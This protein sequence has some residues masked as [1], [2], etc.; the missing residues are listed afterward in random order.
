MKCEAEKWLEVKSKEW[1]S[2]G[3]K[4]GIEQGSENNRRNMSNNSDKGFSI[5]VSHPSSR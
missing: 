3:P 4:E 5:S 1:G 2:E